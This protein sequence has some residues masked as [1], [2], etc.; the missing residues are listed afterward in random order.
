MNTWTQSVAPPA[1]GT[2]GVIRK[3]WPM[4]ANRFRDHLLRLDGASRRMRFAHAVSDGFISEYASRMGAN[5]AIVYGWFHDDVL[6]AT[7][8]LRRIGDA[9]GEE[10]EA[11]FSVEPDFQGRG[12]ATE[13]M[14]RVIR[15][16]RNRGVRH[17]VMTC[18]AD[19]AKM[20]AVARHYDADL[21]FEQGEVVGELLP[22]AA[23]AG[24][25]M[26]EAFDDRMGYLMAVFDLQ[27][28]AVK[29][30]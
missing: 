1:A 16:A 8:E 12:V 14:G 30:A 17:L 18:L 28:R 5:G 6:R 27:T 19:N 15:S 3:L 20:Q 9:W 2:G 4:E 23:S 10:A 24:S 13:L 21:R 11:A 25:L 29:A 7:A 22:D 26:A